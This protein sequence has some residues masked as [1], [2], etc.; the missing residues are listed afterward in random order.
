[1]R[2]IVF[3]L[4]L[5]TLSGYS[6]TG[7][8]VYDLQIITDTLQELK[9]RDDLR[10]YSSKQ[11]EILASKIDSLQASERALT[12]KMQNDTYNYEREKAILANSLDNA[13]R[14]LEALRDSLAS[15]KSV[16]E[17]L[18]IQVSSLMDSISLIHDDYV[19]LL[20]SI[21]QSQNDNDVVS[22]N[23]EKE[24][25]PKHSYV[26]FLKGLIPDGWLLL[27][28]ASGDLNQDGILDFVFAIKDTDPSYVYENEG[29][30]SPVIDENPRVMAIYFGN[31]TGSFDE[32]L[33]SNHFIIRA[34]D[35]TMAEPFR[36]FAINDRGILD[37]KFDFWFSAGTWFTYNSS[38]RFRYENSEFV[39]IGFDHDELHR[40]S[41]EFTSHSINFLT[42]KMKITEGSIADEDNAEIQWKNFNPPSPMTIR[43]M[44]TPFQNYLDGVSF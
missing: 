11:F 43:S 27:D 18:N 2:H 25:N 31:Q 34:D 17:G 5:L 13:Q 20:E 14:E 19:L 32:V 1:M 8:N 24:V 9:K 12:A 39:L 42:G 7:Q 29:L 6:L 28:S 40:G 26:E 15:M 22:L 3:S 41:G 35:P 44:V 33:V 21:L 23:V 16:E 36:G 38:H 30:G 37:I 10:E 4:L